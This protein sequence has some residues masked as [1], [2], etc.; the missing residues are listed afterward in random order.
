MKSKVEDLEHF[1]ECNFRW[2][3]S[4]NR[5]FEE[6]REDCEKLDGFWQCMFCVYYVPLSGVFI[7]DWGAC[8]NVKSQYDGTVR[9]E[10]DGCRE[11][12]QADEQWQLQVPKKR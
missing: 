3:D 4:S 5:S 10:H 6:G 1:R 8:T 7:E 2:K 11:F 12:V 9:Y